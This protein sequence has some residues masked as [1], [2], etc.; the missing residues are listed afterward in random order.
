MKIDINQAPP[1]DIFRDRAKYI[2]IAFVLLALAL[3]GLGLMVYGFVS[4]APSSESLET[5]ALVLFVGPAVLFVYFGGKL[6][7]YKKLNPVQSKELADLAERHPEIATY[8]NRLQQSGRPPI[9][10]EFEACQ[11]RAEELSKEQTE[12]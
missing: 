8:C 12:G 11:D 7:A 2:K 10:A 3:G 6:Q 5:M 4:A 9:H 1:A